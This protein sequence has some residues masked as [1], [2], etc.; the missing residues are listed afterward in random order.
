MRRAGLLSVIRNPAQL[1]VAAFAVLIAIGTM[2]LFLPWATDGPIGIGWEDAL[3]VST[4]ATTV[5]G[6]TTVQ[7]PTFSLFGELVILAL[8]QIGG[9]GIM[10]IGSVLALVTMRRIGLRQRMLAQAEIGAVDM[11][12]LS[13]LL[14]AIAKITIVVEGSLALILFVRFWRGGYEDGPISSAY[15]AIFHAVS[16]FNNAGIALYPDSMAGF[17]SDPWVIFPVSFGFILGGLGFPLYVEFSSRWRHRRAERRREE[18]PGSER[19]KPWSLHARITIWSTVVLLIGGPLM[20]LAFEWTNPG[21]LGSLSLFEK[22]SN[23]WFQGTTPR[24]AG[25]NTIDIGL[26]NDTTLLGMSIMMFIGAGPASTSGGIKV[27]TAALLAA[28]IW[29]EIRGERDV[30]VFRRRIPTPMIRQAVAIALL[31]IGFVGMTTLI[32]MASDGLELTDALFE[33]TSAFGTVGLSTGSTGSISTGGHLVLTLAMI[34]GRVGPLTFVTALALRERTRLYR[35]P[36]ER[37]II[38]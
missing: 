5:T 35:H 30:N 24:T 19:A 38:G 21:T 7:I 34:C 17:Q 8:I 36:E 10:T 1:V 28:V 11:G 23:G 25:F 33:S 16:A 3:F 26:L 9:F 20:V 12:E 37:P 15:S 31:A 29:A 22:L 14:K 32:F 4:S 18:V 6:L 2:L 27:T 13:G